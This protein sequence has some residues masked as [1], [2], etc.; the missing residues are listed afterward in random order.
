MAM[1]Y[2]STRLCAG[3]RRR[4]SSAR[5]PE[6]GE[7]RRP[8]A[9]AGIE[10]EAIDTPLPRRDTE[11]GPEVGV[12]HEGARGFDER[13]EVVDRDDEAGAAVGDDVP[14]PRHIRAHDRQRRHPGLDE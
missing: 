11:A 14:G 4:S 2:L 10:A 9:Q 6:L 1:R 7:Q 12:L 3:T 5:A 13:V 8:R